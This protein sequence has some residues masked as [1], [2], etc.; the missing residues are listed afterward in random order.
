MKYLLIALR[1]NR[2]IPET[3]TPSAM[4]RYFIRASFTVTY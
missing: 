4:S 3:A 1:N 2:L